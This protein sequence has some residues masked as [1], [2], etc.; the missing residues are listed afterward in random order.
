MAT[1]ASSSRGTLSL[2]PTAPSPPRRPRPCRRRPRG[3]VARPPLR[4]SLRPHLPAR[5]RGLPAHADAL[6]RRHG[7]GGGLRGPRHPGRRGARGGGDAAPRLRLRRR[8]LALPGPPRQAPA[9]LG[10][11][12]RPRLRDEGAHVARDGDDRPREDPPGRARPAR[13]CFHPG[14][15]GVA[16]ARHRL[17]PRPAQRGHDPLGR[18]RHRL[19]LDRHPRHRGIHG[20]APLVAPPPPDEPRLRPSP[21]LPAGAVALAVARPLRPSRSDGGGA[22]AGVGL[23]LG[24]GGGRGWPARREPAQDTG[25]LHADRP[26]RGPHRR[27][28]AR[29]RGPSRLPDP[30]QGLRARFHSWGGGRP[31][32]GRGVSLRHAFDLE[33]PAVRAGVGLALLLLMAVLLVGSSLGKRLVYD[34]YDKPPH[35]FRVLTHGPVLPQSGQRMPILALSALGCPSP[36]RENEVNA[37]EAGRLLVRL[38]TIVFTLALGLVL[39]GW[40]AEWLG[41]RPALLAPA[42]S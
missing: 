9:P 34:E 42:P 21:R 16:D 18:R 19:A 14:P 33:R 25:G 11:A 38:P 26:H 4:G 31:A 12:P 5:G 41:A 22:A 32:D 36:C 10:A 8:A 28:R 39:W 6:P 35:G 27:A 3:H 17:R 40:A 15:G 13:R 1:R 24:G 30:G 37:T 2:A 20:D 23:P 7:G 29:R